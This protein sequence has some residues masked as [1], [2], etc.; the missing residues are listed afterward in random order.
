MRFI[1]YQHISFIS[2]CHYSSY[3]LNLP[4]FDYFKRAVA[5]TN[6]NRGFLFFCEDFLRKKN[7]NKTKKTN[8]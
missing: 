4:L 2:I 3:A 1:F 6:E 8:K 7:K 5:F